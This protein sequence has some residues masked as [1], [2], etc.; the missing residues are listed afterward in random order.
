[1]VVYIYNMRVRVRAY[2]CRARM[3][4][5]VHGAVHMFCGLAE[6]I[7]CGQHDVC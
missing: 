5:R 6:C 1:M 7:V 2:T 4:L 3:G